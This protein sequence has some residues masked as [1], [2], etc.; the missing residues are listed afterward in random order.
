[1]KILLIYPKFPETF[2][3]FTYALSFI[4]K[5]AAFPPLGLLTVASLLP[6]N[7]PKRLVDLNVERLTDKDLLWADMAFI[8]GMAV[9][10]KSAEQIITRCKALNLKMVAGGPLFTSEPDEFKAVDHLVL[11]EAELTLPAFLSDLQNGAP[12]KLYRASGFCDLGGTPDPSWDLVKMKRYASMNIQFSRGC[13][14]NCEFCNVT[15]LFGHRPRMKSPRQIISELDRIYASGWRS[16]IFFVDDNFIGN[17]GYLKTHLLPALIEWHKDKKGCVFFTETSIN[18]AD[19]PELLDMMVAAGFDSVF[20]GIESPDERSL[21][22]CHKTQNKNRD[23]LESVKLIHRSGLQVMGGFIVGFDSDMPSIFQRQIDF[24]QKSGI[25]T[26][27]VGM[28]QAPPGTR[29]FD[30]LQRESRVVNTF[31]GDNV[32]GTTNIIPRMGIEPLLD[33]Y[34]SIM[35]QIYAPK[36]Y[37][38]RVRTLLRELKAPE[39]NQPLNIQRFLSL[40]RSAVR[41]GVFGK[42]RFRYWQLML[43]TL[44]CKPKLLSVAITLS[45]Y[46]YHYRRICER[47]IY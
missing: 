5:K 1:M 10:R 14:F 33:G 6:A 13:P 24:I 30:R 18:L 20:I 25:V 46:G 9:Q 38:R 11:D 26:A 40:F 4:G 16:G 17:K 47:Y 31:S 7:W 32:D 44:G 28:L 8:G 36:N 43:W 19:D 21:T 12:K 41:L 3:S 29:L 2:W 34:R 15:T 39:I 23:L 45:I 37:Y 22:E 35:K 27:M 42:E